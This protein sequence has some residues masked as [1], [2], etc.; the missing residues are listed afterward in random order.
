MTLPTLDC[1]AP[2]KVNLTLSVRFRRPDGFHE[3]ESWV[4]PIGWQ[5]RLEFSHGT[6]LS[7][8]IEGDCRGVP[9]DEHN[10]VCKAARALANAAG[11]SCDAAIR[12]TKYI[13]AG[14]GL[15]G[16]SSNAAT[17]LLG[18]NRL[19]ELQLSRARLASIAADIGSDVPLFLAG[20]PVV[21]RGR[22]D[23]IEPLPQQGFRGWVALILPP[24]P[25]STPR[26]YSAWKP[27]KSVAAS[28][29]PPWT[30]AGEPAFDLMR[31]LYNDLEHAAFAVHPRLGELHREL[32]GLDG[33]AVRMTGSGSAMFTLFDRQDEAED[34]RTAAAAIVGPDVA[35]RAV[36]VPGGRGS[37]SREYSGEEWNR[38]R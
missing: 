21:M 8:Q 18:L 25:C 37:D 13:P 4:T 28:A 20:G 23:V 27:G 30:F 22:G 34:W 9:G 24:F 32:D 2:A 16:G 14:A 26:V 17:A 29:T 1:R 38:V 33:R 15:G 10:L 7:L 31:R 3:L 11:R 5:D 36:E 35:I 19:W 12:L 6:D